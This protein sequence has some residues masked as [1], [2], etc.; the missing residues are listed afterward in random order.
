MPGNAPNG[1]SVVSRDSEPSYR[2]RYHYE[3]QTRK[4][5]FMRSLIR[6]QVQQIL[7]GD[8]A[9]STD[10]SA[11]AQYTIDRSCRVYQ[12]TH[13]KMFRATCSRLPNRSLM[14][15]MYPRKEVDP[16][17]SLYLKI[18]RHLGKKHHKVV[19][20]F[21]LFADSATVYVFQEYI[22]Q[23]NMV[24]YLDT[25]PATSERQAQFWAKQVY[26]ALDFLG[27]QAIAHRNITPHH[28]LVLPTGHEIWVKLS[29]FQSAIIYFDTTRNDVFYVPCRPAENN[30]S[31]GD[32]GPACYRNDLQT[33]TISLYFRAQFSSTRSLRQPGY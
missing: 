5:L 12:D 25:K 19:F 30:K 26:D 2:E 4:L 17:T 28:L 29:G 10:S 22:E 3:V 23:G 21:D 32:H 6:A 20:T 9:H 11:F 15:R 31:D 18:L 7:L 27:D 33:V 1:S 16:S 24:E 14:V 13:L 8:P